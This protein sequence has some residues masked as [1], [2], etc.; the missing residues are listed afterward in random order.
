MK[1]W[2][3]YSLI[4]LAGIFGAGYFFGVPMT[5][6]TILEMS[7]DY[8]PH[9]FE[10]VVN[11]TDL[12]KNHYYIGENRTPADYGFEDFEEVTFPTFQDTSIQLSGWFVHSAAADSAPTIVL[13]HGRTSNRLKPMKYLE[14]FRSMGL[15][16]A[17]NFFLVDCRNSGNSSPASTQFGNK[18]AEDLTATCLM[19]NEKY[20][21]KD[22]T[23]YAFSMGA[24]ATGMMLWRKDLKAALA[25]TDLIFNKFIF[26][27]GLSDV[28]SLLVKRANEMNLPDFVL[29]DVQNRMTE[30]VTDSEGNSVYN[31]M[32]FSVV[33]KDIEQPVLFLHHEDDMSTPFDMLENELSELNKPNFT[34]QF[35]KKKEGEE[36][37]H[38][39]MLI[40]HRNKYEEV[41][42]AFLKN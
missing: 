7:Y 10:Y 26:D 12:V 40:Q 29:N 13:V 30:D 8:E 33:L 15:D 16:S 6:D 36:F 18:F 25:E 35:F 38:V 17:Y 3:R 1:K 11:D 22:I 37:F 2:I 14:L 31:D 21:V 39:R 23:M 27:S 41:V 32:K 24:I 34:T 28:P 19:L 5:V 20:K 4:S 9:T 42:K